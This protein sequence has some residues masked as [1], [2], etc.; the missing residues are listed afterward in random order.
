M[1][2]AMA[3]T[4]GS[5]VNIN[6]GT[7]RQLQ[8]VNFSTEICLRF[9]LGPLHTLSGLIRDVTKEHSKH[10]FRKSLPRGLATK[11]SLLSAAVLAYRK[12]EEKTSHVPFEIYE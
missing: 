6:N 5:I 8:P 2:E 4:V 10:F 7:G 12:K 3:K 9:N 11:A 1:S